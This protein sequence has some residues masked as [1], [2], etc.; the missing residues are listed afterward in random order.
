M[1]PTRSQLHGWNLGELLAASANVRTAGAQIEEAITTLK[2]Q[3][4]SLPEL[5]VWEGAAHDA[6]LAMFGR[7]GSQAAAF[8]DIAAEIATTLDT[9]YH[10]LSSVK[11]RIDTAV[12]AIENGPLW[13]S[14]AWVVLVRGNQPMAGE[15]GA[16][17]RRAQ[18]AWQ[19]VLNPL[20]LELSAADENAAQALVGSDKDHGLGDFLPILGKPLDAAPDPGTAFGLTQQQRIEAE[21]AAVTVAAVTDED[22]G[23][24]HVKTVTMQDG[25]KNVITTTASYQPQPG[26]PADAHPGLGPTPGAKV[27]TATTYDP[28]GKVVGSVQTITEKDGTI[29]TNTSFPGKAFYS[30]QQKP[31]EQPKVELAIGP[32][33]KPLDPAKQDVFFT[34]PYLTTVGGAVTGLDNRASSG[35][36][37]MLLNES[38]ISGVKIGAKF[39]GP[40]LGVATTLW[41]MSAA[42]NAHDACVAGI[43][44]TLGTVGGT[45]AG[46]VGGMAGAEGG[47][48]A[49][50]TAAGAGMA[51]TWIFGKI[52]EQVGQ[53][54]CR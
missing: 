22:T 53:A 49:V 37:M 23:G 3:C 32:D 34:H 15:Q 2:S 19:K 26:D 52:G 6:A 29:R 41:D 5:K 31:G 14:D 51:G 44:G 45:V 30:A 11:G 1:L 36:S 16:T 21:D 40:A 38:E 17:V 10:A 47:P 4:A 35:K 46:T 25:S 28:S 48:L 43:S 9:A 20:L 27:Q 33:G 13:V 7:S 8:A 42:R 50:A 12:E 39:A 24:S 18:A 54:I